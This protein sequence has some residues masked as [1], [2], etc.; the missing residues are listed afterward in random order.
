MLYRLMEEYIFYL[1]DEQ[2][3][4]EYRHLKDTLDDSNAHYD[5]IIDKK[6]AVITL[7]A[8]NWRTI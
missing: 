8:P 1:E 7:K 3:M 2:E 4:E 6:Y 5:E